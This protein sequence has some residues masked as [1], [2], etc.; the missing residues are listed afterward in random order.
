MTPPVRTVRL[1]PQPLRIEH[2]AARAGRN[3]GGD[4]RK[5]R[6]IVGGPG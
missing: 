5:A 6:E 3:P 4:G 2:R 1:V